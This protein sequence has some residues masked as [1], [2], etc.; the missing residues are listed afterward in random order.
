MPHEKLLKDDILKY[1]RKKGN[2]VT[3]SLLYEEFK[4]HSKNGIRLT[5]YRLVK[6]G[7]VAKASDTRPVSYKAK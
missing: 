2:P 7:L 3:F 4:G 6:D 1:L 5:V